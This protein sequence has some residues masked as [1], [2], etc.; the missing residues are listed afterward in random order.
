MEAVQLEPQQK[1]EVLVVLAA[2]ALQPDQE[3]RHLQHLRV[4]ETQV[5]LAHLGLEEAVVVALE[6]LHQQQMEGVEFKVHPMPPLMV[7]LGLEEL[8][9]QV[10]FLVEVEL[11]QHL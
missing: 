9:L 2:A 5:L 6:Q 10:I 3:A 11:T 1:T 7:A 4:K 8:Q